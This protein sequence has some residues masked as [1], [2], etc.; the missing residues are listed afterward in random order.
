MIILIITASLYWRLWGC[1]KQFHIKCII[2]EAKFKEL[3]AKLHKERQSSAHKE[4]NEE[5]FLFGVLFVFYAML[6]L[7]I[8]Q[9]LL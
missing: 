7:H 8:L 4:G 5:Y 1:V 2:L 3:S 9:V 6:D